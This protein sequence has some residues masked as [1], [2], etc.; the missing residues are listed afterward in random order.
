MDAAER[1]LIELTGHDTTYWVHSIQRAIARA[2]AWE[3]EIHPEC[4]VAKW[5][6]EL[7]AEV[8]A[9]ILAE[10]PNRSSYDENMAAATVL[11][12]ILARWSVRIQRA[13]AFNPN[14]PIKLRRLGLAAAARKEIA[15]VDAALLPDE[16]DEQDRA[17]FPQQDWDDPHHPDARDGT[18]V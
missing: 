5:V 12:I 11:A 13:K 4:D 14:R 6:G 8:D 16:P 15:L 17:Y 3:T 2:G 18:F 7:A 1:Q 9:A 10:K